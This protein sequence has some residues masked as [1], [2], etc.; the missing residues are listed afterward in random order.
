MGFS[1][2][3][4]NQKYCEGLNFYICEDTGN[5]LNILGEFLKFIFNQLEKLNMNTL[6]MTCSEHL[7]KMYELFGFTVVEKKEIDNVRK[8]LLECKII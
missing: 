5:V 3:N 4:K 7:L 1:I 8:Y 6:Y 2:K